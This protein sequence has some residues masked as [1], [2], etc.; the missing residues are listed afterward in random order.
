MYDPVMSRNTM[1][2]LVALMLVILIGGAGAYWA[3]KKY[4]QKQRQEYRCEGKL[5]LSQGGVDAET[6]KKAVISGNTLDETV[7]KH[8]LVAKW[9]LADAEAAKARIVEK[10]TVRVEGMEVFIGY[11]DKD[12]HLAKAILETLMHSFYAKEKAKHG[13]PAKM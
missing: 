3:V 13:L 7:E 12:K 11:Q 6:F 8:S 2:S 10:F 9:N 1:Y 5:T 4:R